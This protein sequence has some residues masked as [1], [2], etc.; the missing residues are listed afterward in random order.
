MDWTRAIDG[1]CER[2]D[3]GY[4]AEPVNALTNLAFLVA[5]FVMWRRC[6]GL[7]EGRIL[8]SI[9]AAI[10]VGSYL[11]HTHATTWAAMAD[12]VPIMGFALCYL[13]LA[14]RDFLRLSPVFSIVGALLFLPYSA[15]LTPIFDAFPF[16]SVSAFYWPL[17]VLFLVY[18]A[19][20][21]AR[22]PDT[23]RSLWQVSGLLCLSLTARSLDESLCAALPIGT[24]FLWHLL[25][26]LLLGLTIETWRRHVSASSAT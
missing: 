17:P 1:Y 25:N 21:R 19:I 6:E 4:W 11:F 10:G 3:P 5:A 22:S 7:R 14:N 26:A 16:F 12:M 20:L 2:T 15:V 8:A 24:H 23:S 18:G 9:L 13:F